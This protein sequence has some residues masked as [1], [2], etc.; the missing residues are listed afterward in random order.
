MEDL[1]VSYF[2]HLP[3]QSTY[4]PLNQIP[5]QFATT[6]VPVPSPSPR[7]SSLIPLPFSTNPSL[8]TAPPTF[9]KTLPMVESTKSVSLNPTS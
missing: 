6:P 8:L 5:L 3:S 7:R 4:P 1:R 2:S 9:S